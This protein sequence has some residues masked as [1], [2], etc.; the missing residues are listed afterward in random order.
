MA[1]GTAIEWAEDSWNPIR[2]RNKKTGVVGHYCVKVS[3]GC[4]HCYAE[5]L[6]TWPI[7][8]DIRYAAQDR[9]KVELFLDEKVLE[10]PLRRKRG[11]DIFPCSMTDLFADFHPDD[12]L[13]K[14]FDVMYRTQQHRYLALTKRA[15]RMRDFIVGKHGAGNNVRFF[16]NIW[17]GTSAESQEQWDE[18]APYVDEMTRLGF[19][20]WASFEPL[21]GEINLRNYRIGWA[22]IGGE[23]GNGARVTIIGHVRYLLRHLQH[24]GITCF[25]KQLGAHPVNHEG[26]PHP[27]KSKKGGDMAE[28]PADLRV[29]EMPA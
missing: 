2:A 29:R 27:L 17:F 11:R 20:T 26:A 21:L 13:G 24:L 14:I 1:E 9:D 15:E 25:V 28:W 8:S 19:N 12:W 18:R 4:K 10:Q 6:Q 3:P 16:R 5:R 7:G 22:V 23:S